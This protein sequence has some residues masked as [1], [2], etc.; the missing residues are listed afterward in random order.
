MDSPVRTES[1]IAVQCLVCA[2]HAHQELSVSVPSFVFATLDSIVSNPW[3]S[4]GLIV[5][6]VLLAPLQH[7]SGNLLVRRAHQRLLLLLQEP[8]RACPG[9]RVQQDLNP[10]RYLRHPLTAVVF[11]ALSAKSFLALYSPRDVLRSQ[12]TFRDSHPMAEPVPLVK[13]ATLWCRTRASTTI[14]CCLRVTVQATVR[15]LSHHAVVRMLTRVPVGSVLCPA[16]ATPP[17]PG[18]PPMRVSVPC[19]CCDDL[20]I[21]FRV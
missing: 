3:L 21:D 9:P 10:R 7:I 17:H 2:R 14:C 6:L 18:C 13:V 5:C 11:V 12:T 19:V 20:F 8:R 1:E 4:A 16:S 15:G